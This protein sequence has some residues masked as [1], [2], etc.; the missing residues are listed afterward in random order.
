MFEGFRRPSGAKASGD[1]LAALLPEIFY[2]VRGEN[3]KRQI[4]RARFFLFFWGRFFP[5]DGSVL[6]S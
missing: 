4:R 5:G 1:Q 6:L 3:K 2:S